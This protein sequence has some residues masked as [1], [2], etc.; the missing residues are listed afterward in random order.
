ML[1][2]VVEVISHLHLHLLLA[3]AADGGKLGHH[4]YVLQV[5]QFT[6]DAELGEFRDACEEKELKV[7]VAILERRVEVAHDVA[8]LIKLVF[9]VNN[10]KQRGIILVDE[11]N[12]LL[13]CLGMSA[14]YESIEALVEINF[15]GQSFAVYLFV[16]GQFAAQFLF[17]FFWSFM[18][19][20]AHV[21]PK[22]W[23]GSPFL[24]HA[25]DVQPLEEFAP[26]LEVGLESRHEQ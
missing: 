25:V 10:I 20:C 22:H 24:L 4:A 8:K 1:S 5:V 2:E 17:Q 16:C 14:L 18:L 26:A 3:Y 23:I 6:E 15:V 19:C 21:K 13:P 9:L 11:D 12:D 7:R